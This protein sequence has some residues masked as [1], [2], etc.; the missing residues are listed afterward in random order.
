ML[1]AKLSDDPFVAAFVEMPENDFTKLILAPLVRA[2][3]YTEVQFHGGAAEKGKDLIAF[4]KD[5]FGA[6]ECTVF[7]V[8][9]ITESV[10]ANKRGTFHDSV[11]QLQQAAE[12]KIPLLDGVSREPSEVIF[13]TPHVV[14]VRMLESR[15]ESVSGLRKNRMKYLDGEKISKLLRENCPS[16][17]NTILK[18]SVNIAQALQ[19]L[20]TNEAVLKLLGGHSSKTIDCFHV[21]LDFWIGNQRFLQLLHDKYLAK[22]DLRLEEND[23]RLGFYKS[24]QCR[25]SGVLITQT[26]ETLDLDQCE[27]GSEAILSLLGEKIADLQAKLESH[28]KTINEVIDKI[29]HE[30]KERNKILH[31]CNIA[32]ADLERTSVGSERIKDV[33]FSNTPEGKAQQAALK[34]RDLFQSK[35]DLLLVYEQKRNYVEVQPLI[36]KD[37]S[38]EGGY[39]STEEQ[40]VPSLLAYA[41]SLEKLISDF[42]PGFDRK[43]PISKAF[44]AI[45]GHRLELLEYENKAKSDNRIK[46]IVRNTYVVNAAVFV[47]IVG[48]IQVVCRSALNLAVANDICSTVFAKEFSN[49]GTN[50]ILLD[51]LADRGFRDG[52][53]YKSTVG[54][55]KKPD[56]LPLEALLSSRQ[57]IMLLGEAGSGKSTSLQAYTKKLVDLADSETFVIFAPLGSVAQHC[58]SPISTAGMLLESLVNFLNA[59]GAC[60]D[61]ELLRRQLKKSS[62]VIVL[63][64]LDEA[65]ARCPDI[66]P[67]LAELRDEYKECQLVV[68]SRELGAVA[69][70][71]GLIPVTLNPFNSDQLESFVDL[72]CTSRDKP[73]MTET[74]LKHI[75]SQ[76]KLQRILRTPLLATILCE[77]YFSGVGSPPRSELQLYRQRFKMMSGSLD[78]AKRIVRR[79][80]TSQDDLED[81]CRKIAFGLH[82]KGL[83]YATAEE[84]VEL[85]VSDVNLGWTREHAK[86]VV[87][88][89]IEPCQLLVLMS[90]SQLV[91]LGHLRFQEYFAAQELLRLHPSDIVPLLQNVLW[92]DVFVFY[93]MSSNS[94]LSFLAN[95][96]IKLLGDVGKETVIRMVETL[97]VRQKASLNFGSNEPSPSTKSWIAS[98]LDE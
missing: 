12:S 19:G 80:F 38:K 6:D 66:G 67:A 75:R 40:M 10:A 18:K 94:I 27:H 61:V 86:K 31:K 78:D 70:T 9:K 93:A 26:E 39:D 43:R 2:L 55:A 76:K 8:K 83:R 51:S 22:A 21:G 37:S 45:I 53:L 24:T 23:E 17:C 1:N 50:A 44:K 97:S 72:Y 82:S 84:H 49:F 13:V 85:L 68:S 16:I 73:Q 35:M 34:D 20:Y 29:R 41:L 47:E 5:A 91:G 25:T 60:L 4:K 42:F 63:D 92:R 56:R 88:E 62:S 64:A 48:S 14:S 74:I 77:I 7:V 58:V 32:L 3:G 11:T 79:I 54:S 96:K 98:I 28:R 95:L 71:L 30:I 81:A 52:L 36:L 57:S 89:L 15:F 59:R 65:T 87:G 46:S 69:R 33:D 90:E